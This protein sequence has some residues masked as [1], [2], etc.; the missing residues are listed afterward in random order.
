[1][2]MH[3][4]TDAD[5][6]RSAASSL[7]TRAKGLGALFILTV[8]IPTTL[9][10]LYFGLLASDVYISESRF[11]VR[12]P[13][14]PAATGL[15]V[16]LK[17]AGFTNAGDEIYAAQDYID[18]R[19]ALAALNRKGM[20]VGVYGNGTISLFDR[21]NPFGFGGTFED[22]Y[23]Y[24]RKKVS[25]EHDTS[26]SIT[27]LTVRAYAPQDALRI[28]EQLL[29]MAEATVNRLNVRGRQDLIQFA[30][31]EVDQAAEKARSAALSLSAYRNLEGVVDPEKQA[32][33]QIQMVSKLQDELIASRTELLQVRAVAPDNPQIAT[34]QTRID[35][36][37]RQIQQEYG[38]IAGNPRSLSSTAAR[39]QRLALE[40]QFADKQLASAMASLQEAQN[41]ARRKQAYVE[42]IVQPNL[43]DAALEPRRLKGILAT[44]VLGL[45]V[46]GALSMLIA[47]VREHK[48]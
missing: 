26:S 39:Y 19:D 30:Q 47:G 29:S 15:G 16:L 17:S 27:T 43:P 42:R 2:L 9:A 48:S 14:K 13:D 6:Q 23:K 28:N 21:F 22:L 8:A 34:L 10:I 24:Y 20:V 12:S 38:K 31:A 25:V 11:V 33:V 44:F 41:E 18:S 36:L 46:W 5:F 35:G 7:V 32:A 45:I 40:S 4:W 3:R 37:N 1:M